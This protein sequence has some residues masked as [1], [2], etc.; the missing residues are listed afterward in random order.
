M[1]YPRVRY[2]PVGLGCGFSYVVGPQMF[3]L[4]RHQ[5]IEEAAHVETYVYGTLVIEGSTE[6]YFGIVHCFRITLLGGW[7]RLMSSNTN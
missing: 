6:D 4:Y 3:P 1:I 5:A 2:T 7:T